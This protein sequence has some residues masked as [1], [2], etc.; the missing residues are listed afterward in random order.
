MLPELSSRFARGQLYAV[1]DVL[2]NLRDL[3]E[4]KASI[5]LGEA[6]AAAAAM[7]RAVAA[8]REGGDAARAAAAEIEAAAAAAPTAPPAARRTALNEVFVT[9][10]ERTDAL[11]E[12]AAQAAR[13]ALGG[14][15]A[16]QAVREVML[17]KP[18]MLEEISRG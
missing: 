18:S 16:A 14:H 10:L 12:P 7:S 9:A 3:V 1:L 2:R 15:L 11:D 4:E 5:L 17:R 6:D 13:G 8:L